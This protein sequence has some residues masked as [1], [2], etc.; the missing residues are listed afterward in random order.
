MVDLPYH[1][2]RVKKKNISLVGTPQSTIKPHLLVF[3][4]KMYEYNRTQKRLQC[5]KDSYHSYISNPIIIC[6]FPFTSEFRY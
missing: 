3:L 2:V 5:H 1:T 6:M 4:F